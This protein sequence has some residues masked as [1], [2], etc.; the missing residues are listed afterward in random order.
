MS[1]EAQLDRSFSYIGNQPPP[2][3]FV[4]SASQALLRS[5][6][7]AGDYAPDVVSPAILGMLDRAGV[8]DPGPPS[9]EPFSNKTAGRLAAS[10]YTVI[11]LRGQSI[12]EMSVDNP[13]GTRYHLSTPAFAHNKSRS[14]EV[15]VR[16]KPSDLYL[17]D[18]NNLTLKEREVRIAEANAQLGIP[19]AK[20]VIGE[21]ADH[22]GIALEIYRMTRGRTRLHGKDYGN[23]YAGTATSN[24]YG[25]EG[26]YNIGDFHKTGGLSAFS[27]KADERRNNVFI[28]ALVVPD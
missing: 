23:N 16:I 26:Y 5:A 3:R 8:I 10:G 28:V 13:L 6:R 17:P 24:G 12:K 27:T 19:G 15:A 18:S 20:I 11:R 25:R 14:S 21:A 1:L 22:V 9:P 7:S 4:I 2:Q